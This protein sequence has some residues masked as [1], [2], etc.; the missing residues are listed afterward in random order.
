MEIGGAPLLEYV[1]R[2]GRAH[3]LA[4]PV[5]ARRM[6]SDRV[7]V[8]SELFRLLATDGPAP[9]ARLASRHDVSAD[10]RDWAT[11]VVGAN[12]S[13][14]F[15][16]FAEYLCSGTL[17]AIGDRSIE[18]EDDGDLVYGLTAG[19]NAVRALAGGAWKDTMPR[20]GTA[21]RTA[22]SAEVRP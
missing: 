18:D 2:V 5:I 21:V 19:A 1:A 14:Q 13:W 20:H 17:S 3:G 4:V 12:L 22:R 11:S 6:E 7:K 8:M 15:D 10:L 16:R 9:L